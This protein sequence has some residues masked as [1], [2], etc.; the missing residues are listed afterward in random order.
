LLFNTDINFYLNGKAGTASKYA[1]DLGGLLSSSCNVSFVDAC[2]SNATEN[3]Q[4]VFPLIQVATLVVFVS[5]TQGNGELPSLARKFMSILFDRHGN[6]LREKHCAVLGF[7]SSNYPIFCGAASQLSRMLAKVNANEIVPHG[8]CDSVKGEDSTFYD[9]AT[10][11]VKQLA[12]MNGASQLML[13][14]SSD[15]KDSKSSRLVQARSMLNHVKV[16]VFAANDVEISVVK[17][18]MTMRSGSMGTISRRMKRSGETKSSVEGTMSASIERI[19]QIISFSTTQ[20]FNNE[21]RCGLVKCRDDIISSVAG[22]EESEAKT[23]KTSVVKIAL[24][25]CGGELFAKCLFIL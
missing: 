21:I 20:S 3:F 4:Q 14:L 22:T 15:L 23:R 2:G 13:K 17:S 10:N 24:Q 19:V 9:W 6:L 16:E 12:C 8:L 25:S 7:G 1:S 5:S 18:F 11:L